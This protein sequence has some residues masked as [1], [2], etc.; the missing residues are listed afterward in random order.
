MEANGD[1]TSKQRISV[2]GHRAQGRRGGGE[3]PGHPYHERRLPQPRMR[4]APGCGTPRDGSTAPATSFAARRAGALPSRC[5]PNFGGISQKEKRKKVTFLE[6]FLGSRGRLGTED[7]IQIRM[8]P[9]EMGEKKRHLL[10]R[11][12]RGTVLFHIGNN[13]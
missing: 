11:G 13:E 4:K 2:R 1:K 10:K 7:H 8:D 9:N 5:A 3:G 6:M 12:K